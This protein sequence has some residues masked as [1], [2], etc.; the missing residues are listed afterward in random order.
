MLY[1]RLCILLF[2]CCLQFSLLVYLARCKRLLEFSVE[3]GSDRD[4]RTR[5]MRSNFQA[6][7]G[8][9]GSGSGKKETVDLRCSLFCNGR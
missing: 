6:G 2:S 4:A 8:H 7:H 5:W 1:D 3:D 9:L